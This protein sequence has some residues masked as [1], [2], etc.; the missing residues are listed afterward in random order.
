MTLM[1]FNCNNCGATLEAPES[2][3]FVTCNYCRSHLSI[4]QTSSAVYTE[5]IEEIRDQVCDLQS[6]VKM[7]RLQKELETVDLAWKEE[8]KQYVIGAPSQEV[9]FASFNRRWTGGLVFICL[10][11]VSIL[12]LVMEWMGVLEFEIELFGV[13]LLS[14]LSCFGLVVGIW[15]MVTSRCGQDDY[16]QAYQRYLERRQV[17]LDEVNGGR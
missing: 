16:D 7:L 14:I 3:K 15:M 12:F 9:A 2:A 1:S 13:V 10:A 8:E 4:T 6:E 11:L 17:V 5:V